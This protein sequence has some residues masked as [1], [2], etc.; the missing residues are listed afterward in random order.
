VLSADAY[1]LFEELGIFSEEAAAQLYDCILSRGGSVPA[2]VL[3]RKFRG[4]DATV[5]A[6]LRHSGIEEAHV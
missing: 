2:A 3:Y 5:D 6:L 1:S 4:R